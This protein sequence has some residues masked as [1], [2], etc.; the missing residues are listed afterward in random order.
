[1]VCYFRHSHPV[2]RVEDFIERGVNQ[3]GIVSYHCDS[4]ACS[5]PDVLAVDFCDRHLELV[6]QAVDYLLDLSPFAQSLQVKEIQ[7]GLREL[8]DHYG[9]KIGKT[10]VMDTQNEPFPIPVTRDIGGILIQE[11]QKISYLM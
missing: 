9:V 8:L 7:S 3:G 10:M 11:I 5:L 2:S 6:P 1:M 4:Y